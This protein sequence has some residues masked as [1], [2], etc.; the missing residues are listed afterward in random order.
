MTTRGIQSMEHFA[1][2]NIDFTIKERCIV[3]N[4]IYRVVHEMQQ[5]EV[6]C[7]KLFLSYCT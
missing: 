2:A 1:E 7:G 3:E 4:Y 5:N 6:Y